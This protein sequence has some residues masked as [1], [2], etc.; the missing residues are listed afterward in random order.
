MCQP[1]TLVTWEQ[2]ELQIFCTFISENALVLVRL[3]ILSFDEVNMVLYIFKNTQVA[4]NKQMLPP[5]YSLVKSSE[6]S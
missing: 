3:P 6:T 4:G 5:D 2:L 1:H